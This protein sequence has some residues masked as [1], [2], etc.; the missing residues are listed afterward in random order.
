MSE[1]EFKDMVIS[2]AKRYGWLVHHDLPAQNTRGRW[3]TNVQ[4]DVG[5]PDLFMV[6]PFQA[7]RP[8]VI[9][10]KAEK[11]KTTPGQKIWLNACELA[12]RAGPRFRTSRHGSNMAIRNRPLL[13]QS[14]K[15]TLARGNKSWKHQRHQ[16]GNSPTT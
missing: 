3:M 10:L 15:K 13:Q 1:A 16:L 14:P 2:I 12:G 7:G 4:G 5:F 6:H 9:E 8:L 11:G